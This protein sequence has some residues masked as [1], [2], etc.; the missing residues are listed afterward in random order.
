MTVE[1]WR[2]GATP[3]PAPEIGR[4]AAR[5]EELGWDGLVVG[6]DEGVLA[7]SYVV[8]ATAAAATQRLKLGTGVAV[9]IRDPMLAA[10]AVATLHAVSGGRFL[11]SLGRGD[12]A[13]AQLGR[14]PIKVDEFETYLDRVQ[15]YLRRESFDLDG[16][17][18]S[19]ARIFS[20][21]PGLDLPKPPVDVSATGPRMIKLAARL[22]EGITFAV[23][24]N[25]ERLRECVAAA[26]AARVELGL[27]PDTFRLGAYI[28]AAVA[29][30]GD[31]DVARDIIRGGVLRHA[32]FS[33]LHGKPLDTAPEE[34]RATLARA[35]EATRDHGRHVPKVADFSAKEIIDDEY[36]DR[37]AVVGPPEQ[38]AERFQEI[39][40]TGVDRIVVLVRV[41]GT[42]PQEENA[43]RL[44]QEV[45]PLLRS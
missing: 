33:V 7:E 23:G 39:I 11:I 16:F 25:V 10:N 21:D 3:A 26:R 19:M 20:V 35:F 5:F 43:A 34:D 17:T 13:L 27:D 37:F 1:F 8:L 28:P 22:A 32:R 9:P 45:F 4:L 15:R 30:N 14:G 38:C 31:L 2:F 40:D 12:G 29:P 6:E 18:A 42:D 36:L 24:A 44:A 41:P